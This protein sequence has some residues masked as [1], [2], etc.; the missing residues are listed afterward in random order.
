M[1]LSAK[2]E[3]ELPHTEQVSFAALQRTY[4]ERGPLPFSPVRVVSKELLADH[5]VIQDA[6][7]PG[8]QGPTQ[9]VLL[10]AAV[11]KTLSHL[12][13]RKPLGCTEKKLLTFQRKR[14]G[15]WFPSFHRVQN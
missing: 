11:K 12:S 2:L 4:N 5:C 10:M 15:R 7:L 8:T 3:M 14:E 9:K 6:G 13:H 1:A